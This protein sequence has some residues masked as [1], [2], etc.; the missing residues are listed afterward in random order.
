MQKGSPIFSLC[1]RALPFFTS[2]LTWIP[3]N[4]AKIKIWEDSILGDQPLNGLNK[5]RNIK[6]WLLANNCTTMWDISSWENNDKESWESWNLGNYSDE[7]KEEALKLLELLQGKSP[8]SARSKDKRGWGSGSGNYTAAN[9]YADILEL[10][11]APPNP[12]PW[13]AL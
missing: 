8:I 12:A 6:A 1:K 3:G 9:G 5:L 4:G 2:K 11:W 10:P 13:K 7:L